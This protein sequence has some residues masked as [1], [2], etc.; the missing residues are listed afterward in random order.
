[1]KNTDTPI[2]PT[3]SAVDKSMPVNTE[4][5]TTIKPI[6]KQV[7]DYAEAMAIDVSKIV[8]GAKVVHAKFGDGEIASID[9]KDKYITVRFTVGEKKFVNPDGFTKGFLKFKE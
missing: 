5:K 2:V 7:N 3:E 6:L 8:V 4:V 9:K 1:M